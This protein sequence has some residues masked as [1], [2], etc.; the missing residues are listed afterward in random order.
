[1]SD[2]T[3]DCKAVSPS[4]PVEATVYG[5]APNLGGN[6]FYAVV[7]AICALI[8][9]YHIFRFWRSWKVFSIMTFIGCVGECCGYIGRLFL[10]KNPWN[11]AA[12]PIQL[13]LLMV[14]PS[15]LAAALYT[16]LRTLV[17]YFGPEHTRMPARFWTWPFVTADL[18]GFFL[19]CGGGIL[20]STAEKNPSLGSVGNTIMIFG[21]SFQAVIMAIAGL[22]TAD[23][24]LRIGRR[25][26]THVFADL[27]K[28]LRTFLLAMTAAFV[29]ILARC[30]YRIPEMAGGV[31]GPL[32]R[33]EADFMIFD[34]LLI[35]LAVVLQSAVHP[36]IFAGAMQDCTTHL[37]ELKAPLVVN[38]R[39]ELHE[40]DQA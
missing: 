36:G 40:L 23:F 27:P 16:T 25:H 31:G 3:D 19:Q 14:S 17:Q 13:V 7:F 21:V 12:L 20:A 26:G 1:M 30:I 22:L 35:L 24:T 5:Y 37:Y 9:F 18:V 29:L 2:S 8:Q 28:D 4:C 11:G 39:S 10:H 34:G 6:A 33:K 15:F 32:M 38:D